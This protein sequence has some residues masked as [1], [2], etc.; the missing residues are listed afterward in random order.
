MS[1]NIFAYFQVLESLHNRFDTDKIY[2]FTGPILIAI[3]P[4]K[5]IPDL[6]NS[7]TL[8]SFITPEISKT[9]HVF[10]TANA[11]YRGLCNRRVPQTVLISGESGAGKTETTK[12]VM[13]FLASAGSQMNFDP[14]HSPTSAGIRS[15]T[16][17]QKVLESN[18]LLEAFGNARTLRNDN[19]SRFGK[20]IELQ[21]RIDNSTMAGR[22]CGARVE[23]YLLE[24]VRVC[25]QQEGERNYHI[26]YQLC[27]AAARGV[28]ENGI[29]YVDNELSLDLT[30]YEDHSTFRYLTKSSWFELDGIDDAEQLVRTLQAMKT[31]GMSKDE[32]E[33]ILRVVGGVL[34]L[35]NLTFEKDPNNSEG[36]V[37]APHTMEHLKK[38]AKLLSVD[39]ER[40]SDVLTHR[41][42]KTMGESYSRALDISQ[43][44]DARDALARALYGTLFLMV[45]K[46]I[47][48]SL[49]HQALSGSAAATIDPQLK[50]GVLDIFG[51]ECFEFNSFEQLCIN[52]TNERLQ[53]FFNTFVFK[54]EEALYKNEGIQWDPLDFPDNQDCVD[55][56]QSVPSGVFA[57]L[58]E[59]CIVPQGSDKSFAS[60][61]SKQHTGKHSRFAQVK[62][63]P[64]WFIVNHFAGP[65]SYCS[66]NFLEKNRDQLL[67][68]VQEAVS[69]S[70]S[71]FVQYLFTE[72]LHRKSATGAANRGKKHVTV[73]LEF[74]DQLNSLMDTVKV[75][76]P[77][78]I[79][80]IKP[81]PANQP[82]DFDRPSV[83]EQLRYGGV[84]QAVQVSRAGYPI[85]LKHAECAASYLVLLQKAAAESAP[86]NAALVKYNSASDAK[87]KAEILLK[88][89]DS[90]LPITRPALQPETVPWAVGSTLCFFKQEAYESLSTARLKL[91]GRAA[92]CIQAQWRCFISR[93]NFLQDLQRVIKAQAFARGKLAKL[94]ARRLREKRAIVKVQKLVRGFLVRRRIT[95]DKRCIITLQ[96][97]LRT[98]TAVRNY[99]PLRE[100]SAAARI[101]ALWKGRREHFYFIR[102]KEGVR[103]AQLKWRSILAR[104]Q[105][106]R[107]KQEAKEAGAL[108][109]KVQVMQEEMSRLSKLSQE[110]EARRYR[111]QRELRAKTDAITK[112]EADVAKLNMRISSELEPLISSL[113]V[114]LKEVEAE[115]LTLK[116]ENTQL[117]TE[118][119]DSKAREVNLPE[120]TH[121]VQEATQELNEKDKFISELRSQ[122][123]EAQ[124]LTSTA[125]ANLAKFKQHASSSLPPLNTGS[126]A[127]LL[128]EGRAT[129]ER[130]VQTDPISFSVPS[131]QQQFQSADGHVATLM[132]QQPA[133]TASNLSATSQDRAVLEQQ[134]SSEEKSS[135]SW[136][137]TLT[138]MIRTP[139]T[140]PSANPSANSNSAA[141][142]SG[143]GTSSGNSIQLLRSSIRASADGRAEYRRQREQGVPHGMR[144][145]DGWQDV[146]A[147]QELQEADS[148]VTCIVFGQEKEHLYY[149]L[150]ASAAK[151]GTIVIYRV[152]R[153]GAEVAALPASE[154][155][156]LEQKLKQSPNLFDR[157]PKSE[158]HLVN[159]HCRL[160]GHSRAVTSIFFSLLEDQLISTSIDKT[161]RF[162][163]AESG[164]MLKVFTDSSPALVAAFL[165]F[166]P[167]V[168]VAANSNRVVRL[169]N[170]VLGSVIQKLKVESEIRALRFDDTGLFC[171]AGT[172]N[173]HIHVFEAA[174]NANL[175]FKFKQQLA[176]GAITCITFVP[177]RNDNDAATLFINSCDST[178]AIVDCMYGPP[179]VL[180]QLRVRHR[181]KVAHSLLPLRSCYASFGGGFLISGSEDKEVYVYSMDPHSNYKMH[182][183]KHHNAPVLSVAANSTDSLLV[184]ADSAGHM[185]FWRRLDYTAL[186]SDQP[187]LPSKPQPLMI[188]Q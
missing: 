55:L 14:S 130:E 136:M 28:D 60:K 187:E 81:N 164:E 185:V 182:F 124:R 67:P 105:L 133:T 61:L 23:T 129:T 150:L 131:H 88:F 5:S 19:S 80:C 145:L 169:V 92:T 54:V 107:L 148:A 73:S 24:K 175:K 29:F 34:Y 10:A 162:W 86:A 15:T 76:E 176:H 40:L 138:K 106:R 121:A 125:E 152:Y 44:D 84:L 158:L 135:W 151:D 6:Y 3:N 16:I 36:A 174:D 116:N 7:D 111:D 41:M 62:T 74:R 35:G 173:G 101:Q 167:Q 65:V 119:G 171:L 68:D 45:A 122:L 118:L 12:F 180:S 49:S 181:V 42:I 64:S 154:R 172:K 77:H 177:A 163:S 99:G 20:F 27:A 141:N 149:S 147:V 46:R 22:V 179:G 100:N 53:Q 128:S 51:F 166:N 104:R 155:K 11:A 146:R 117:A 153:T 78:F 63:K 4:F 93:R 98:F 170:V 143:V 69:K 110:D 139:G 178:V 37:V 127:A 142:A 17:E 90:Y 102:L 13:K 186:P 9:P 112:Y 184:S 183:L 50:C 82:D 123:E 159:V 43:A 156:R 56:L 87:V 114:K 1:F 47:N 58:D 160:H 137:N 30:G 95:K 25:D 21:F 134:Q 140:T 79:R 165:P 2:T 59:E 85:R 31:V 75:T 115:N 94:T 70:E 91:R 52:F 168:F 132:Q 126:G 32:M 108:L 161:V 97:V 66:D 48:E 103:A 157:P 39:S 120:L 71:P 38:A 109:A 18:P 144:R 8:V 96:S 72:L 188:Q 113:Q 33:D 83:N 89:L 57:M 26:F